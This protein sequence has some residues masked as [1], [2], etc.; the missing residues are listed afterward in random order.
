MTATNLE[1][2]ALALDTVTADLNS[3][4]DEAF[5]SSSDLDRV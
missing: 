5:G 3:L 1:T 2:I 4:I